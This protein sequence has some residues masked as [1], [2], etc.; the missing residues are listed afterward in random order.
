MQVCSREFLLI[1][2][3]PSPPPLHYGYTHLENVQ[4]KLQ[5]FRC[6]PHRPLALFLSLLHIPLSLS[7]SSFIPLPRPTDLGIQPREVIVDGI[8][9]GV[10]RAR[11]VHA[12][13]QCLL[14]LDAA[15][16]VVA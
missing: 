11:L 9:L 16:G 4:L 3:L 7:N 14:Q 8:F 10:F 2:P 12:C 5:L 6:S 13:A 15:C 1:F